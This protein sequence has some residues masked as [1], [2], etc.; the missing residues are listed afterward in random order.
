MHQVKQ[1]FTNAETFIVLYRLGSMPI[2]PPCHTCI[3]VF[4]GLKSNMLKLHVG[5]VRFRHVSISL[6][7]VDSIC[8]VPPK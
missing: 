4:H 7:A 1:F 2:L 3:V 8:R 5:D 6:Y